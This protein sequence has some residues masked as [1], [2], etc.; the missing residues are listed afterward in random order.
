MPAV[1][2]L[3]INQQDYVVIPASE[4]DK[5]RRANPVAKRARGERPAKAAI[6]DVM[7]RT[8]LIRRIKARLSQ[9]ELAA[10]AGVRPETISRIESG[11]YR[12]QRETMARLDRALGI[13]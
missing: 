4:Y 12:P 3:R 1:G 13:K 2:K 5:L 6:L 11:R 9:E 10:K 7:A 8:L